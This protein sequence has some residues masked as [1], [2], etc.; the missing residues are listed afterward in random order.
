MCNAKTIDECTEKWA[1]FIGTYTEAQELIEY[2]LEHQWV[3][4]QQ[5]MKAWTSSYR[6]FGSTT[7]SPIES[8]HSVAKKWLG[9]S[10]GDLLQVRLPTQLPVTRNL[11]INLQVVKVLRL[12]LD[13]Q[14]QQV[15]S[16]MANSLCR[17]PWRVL[18]KYVPIFPPMIN[19][20]I[21]PGRT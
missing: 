3:H 7:T 8:L 1:A 13:D 18:L 15:R 9:V 2:L 10:T 17:P 21:T 19:E 20:A 4:R 5:F 11:L 16:K 12:M 6:H 14:H